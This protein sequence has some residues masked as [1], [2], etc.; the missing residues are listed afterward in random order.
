MGQ[1]ILK[2][3]GDFY[4]GIMLVTS[5]NS[6]MKSMQMGM[7]WQKRLEDNDY[8]PD[9][10]VFAD[11]AFHKQLDELRHSQDDRSCQMEMDIELK[12][13][14]GKKLSG[15]EMLYLKNHNR[16]IYQVA[17]KIEQERIVYEKAL[18]SCTTK[19]EVEKLKADYAATAVKRI[20][21]IRN[22]PSI[23]SEEKQKLFSV[24]YFRA[25]ALDDTMHTFMDS[26]DYK[27]LPEGEKTR[28]DENDEIE[29][30]AQETDTK[31]L[32][33]EQEMDVEKL[34]P[35]REAAADDAA[36]EGSIMRAIL[37]E[38]ARWAMEEDPAQ[39]EEPS[40]AP[41][42]ARAKAAYLV[43]QS[44]EAPVETSRVD[45]RK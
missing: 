45:I 2:R 33:P 10:G 30:E 19:E 15:E 39:T 24:E 7:K 32:L 12:M 38:E 28:P 5:I 27:H 42:F 40:E 17:K 11:D 6:Y 43:A 1:K 20:N 26:P 29:N 23:S 41:Q 13:T 9:N 3:K 36:E 34:I 22:N 25:A 44:Y 18:A 35:A 14:A 21:A 16:S 4:M 31:K 37:D 8:S